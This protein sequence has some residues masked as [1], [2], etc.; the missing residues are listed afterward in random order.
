MVYTPLGTK[1]AEWGRD[2]VII[3]VSSL[4]QLERNL[5]DLEKGP[6]PDDVIKALDEAWLITKPTTTN[7][8]HLDLKYTYDTQRALFKPKS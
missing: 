6:L 5:K 1:D 8:W 4:A 3:G 2:G 7:Y